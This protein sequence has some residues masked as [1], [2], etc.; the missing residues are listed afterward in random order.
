MKILLIEE[1]GNGH[2]GQGLY[3]V[4]KLLTEMGCEEPVASASGNCFSICVKWKI[5]GRVF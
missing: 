2:P 4:K 3:I 1:L 5:T